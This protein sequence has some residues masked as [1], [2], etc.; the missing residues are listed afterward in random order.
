VEQDSAYS[1]PSTNHTVEGSVPDVIVVMRCDAG[2][3]DGPTHHPPVGSV[4]SE[5]GRREAGG[6]RAER[7]RYVGRT[8]TE[9]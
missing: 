4:G 2:G 8:V 9:C 7:G 1:D 6:R 3:Q 5:G